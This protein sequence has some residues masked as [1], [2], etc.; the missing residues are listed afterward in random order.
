[1]TDKKRLPPRR[2][3]KINVDKKPS[4]P[5]TLPPTP[6]TPSRRPFRINATDSEKDQILITIR[7]ILDHM[8]SLAERTPNFDT[9]SEIAKIAMV[10]I[11][12]ALQGRVEWV[13]LDLEN[14]K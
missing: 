6:P 7:F 4:L 9:R 3:F 8:R 14:K 11:E 1:M 10:G 12:T 2:P 13:G 5:K